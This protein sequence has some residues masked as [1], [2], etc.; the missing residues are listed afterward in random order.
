MDLLNHLRRDALDPSY[1]RAAALTGGQRARPGWLA[2]ALLVIGLILGLAVA[3]TWR[4]APDAARERAQVIERI[5]ATDRALSELRLRQAE[6]SREVRALGR[7]VSGLTPEQEE[8]DARLGALTGTDPVRGP[9]VRVT[10]DDGADTSVKGSRVVDTDVRMVANGLWAAGAEA[11]SVNGHRLS[12]R[13]AIRNAG[14]AITVDYRSLNRPYVVEAI[15]DPRGLEAGLKASEG[16]R[17]MEGLAQHYGIVWSM[18]RADEVMLAADPG[19]GVERATPA[20]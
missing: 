20:R 1:A 15:G 10:V 14:D 13:T 18:A 8:L 12:V 9:G 5:T 17:W 16:G 6:L 4:S 19:L 11:V 3:N 2:P 7:P